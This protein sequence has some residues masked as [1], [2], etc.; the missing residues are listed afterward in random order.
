VRTPAP[1]LPVAA[2]ADPAELARLEAAEAELNARAQRSQAQRKALNRLAQALRRSSAGS[3]AAEGIEQGDYQRAADELDKLGAE[4]DQLSRAAKDQL[5]RALAEAAR[6]TTGNPEL[7]EQERQAARAFGPGGSYEQQQEALQQL[8]EE[9]QRAGG[10]VVEHGDLAA[11]ME[12]IQQGRQG[13]GLAPRAPIAF[14]EP[15]GAESAAPGQEGQQATGGRSQ[16][17]DGDQG[18]GQQPGSQEGGRS[19]GG[20]AGQQSPE[21]GAGGPN[22]RLDAVGRPVDVPLQAGDGPASGTAERPS[23][24]EVVEDVAGGSADPDPAA[25]EAPA[26]AAP[27][28]NL[29][30]S[31]RRQVVRDYF[32][33]EGR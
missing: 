18:S 3:A 13:Q 21:P 29:V 23:G 7:A 17:L 33:G 24:R 9:V 10:Q 5:S 11:E 22:Q 27:E 4:A 15:A 25:P 12:R 6:E 16:G 1:A 28:R 30:P 32:S 26:G 20:G 2:P 8:G 14:A 31:D 19:G